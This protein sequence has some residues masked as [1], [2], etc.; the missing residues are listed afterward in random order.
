MS[1]I[2]G[3]TSHNAAPG[4][5]FRAK[6]HFFPKVFRHGT[7]RELNRPQQSRS[8]H[9]LQFTIERSGTEP[10]TKVENFPKKLTPACRIA[11]YLFVIMVSRRETTQRPSGFIEPCRPTKA[12]RP[13]SGP[14]WVHEI[15]H[16][17]FRLL[18]RK[19]GSR[20]R[21]FTRN[22]YNWADRFPAIVEAARRLKATSFLIDGGR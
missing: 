10:R 1:S 7:L 15:K 17:G 19:E 9:I 2:V 18:V 12:P 8:A 16:D 20:V 11:A 22:G 3:P 4:R 14:E 6:C 5:L 13:P 21:C